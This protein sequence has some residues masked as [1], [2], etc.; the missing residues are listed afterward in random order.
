MKKIWRFIMNESSERMIRIIYR[1]ELKPW[2]KF[3]IDIYINYITRREKWWWLYFILSSFLFFFVCVCGGITLC[4]NLFVIACVWMNSV[5]DEGETK[6]SSTHICRNILSESILIHTVHIK[7][8]PIILC[9]WCCLSLSMLQTILL[10]MN[11]LKK[12]LLYIFF[13]YF[14]STFANFLGRHDILHLFGG[15]GSVFLV[16]VYGSKL[17]WV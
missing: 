9:C 8:L 2:V 3:L 4:N 12:I 14:H 1:I 5:W 7:V 16:W 11:F 6:D 17:C 10:V 13:F 15:G